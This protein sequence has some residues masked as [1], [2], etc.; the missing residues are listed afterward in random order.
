MSN[1][2]D[3]YLITA[4][5]HFREGA[6][7]SYPQCKFRDDVYLITA[8]THFRE[9]AYLSYPQCKF[10]DNVCEFFTFHVTP[11]NDVGKHFMILG[12]LTEAKDRHSGGLVNFIVSGIQKL[13]DRGISVHILFG[14]HDRIP[15]G[16]PFFDF[17]GAAHIVKGVNIPPLFS[18]W[19]LE[20]NASIALFHGPVNGFESYP[21]SL[22][23]NGIDP[24]ALL[25]GHEFA[26]GGDLHKPLQNKGKIWYCGSPY[27]TRLSYEI[28][29]H[30]MILVHSFHWNAP[31]V[32]SLADTWRTCLRGELD[33]KFLGVGSNITSVSGFCIY[34]MPSLVRYM[35]ILV[36]FKEEDFGSIS[37]IQLHPT[38][39]EIIP[40]R[41][42]ADI[43]CP[44]EGS[45][46]TSDEWEAWV[47]SLYAGIR[48]VS[49][50]FTRVRG[51]FDV[52]EIE[53]S[54]PVEGKQFLNYLKDAVRK[55]QFWSEDQAGLVEKIL[56]S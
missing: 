6:Y 38:G 12:D 47:K 16:L 35:N 31:K 56:D 18:Q 28:N 7:L 17:L 15:D 14:N 23:E 33:L 54:I 30:G 3:I 24:D 50:R 55:T 21:G 27:D 51:N 39:S 42:V 10:W 9:G 45:S 22:V 41:M 36:R 48:E 13:K 4:D 5:T 8:D 19:E 25:K 11:Y 32:E 52:E 53:K 20:N 37:P 29:H 44:Y 2:D 26:I 43:S 34:S 40:V 46:H 49:I 1:T